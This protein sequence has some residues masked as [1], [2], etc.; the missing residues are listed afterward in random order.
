[1]AMLRPPKVQQVRPRALGAAEFDRAVAAHEAFV[2]GRSGGARA[3]LR[4]VVAQG[5]RCDRRTL[6]D[7]DFGG[8]DFTGSSFMASDLSRAVFYC[9]NLQ[10]C[11]LRAANLFEADLRGARL[12]GAKLVGAILDRANLRSAVLSSADPFAGGTATLT[13]ARLDGVDLSAVVA[14]GAD[15][16]NCSLKGAI[17]RHADL[18]Y[19]NLSNANLSGAQLEGVQLAG[20]QLRGAVL[21][22]VDLSKLS[23]PPEVLQGCVTDPSPAAAARVPQILAAL[24]AMDAWVRSGGREG[25]PAIFDN[26]DLRPVGDAFA[27]RQLPGVSLRNVMAIDASFRKAQLAGARFDGADLRG[28]DFTGADLR[29]VSFR[30]ANLAHA[31]FDEAEL[32]P[33]ALVNGMHREVQLEG[34]MLGGSSLAAIPPARSQAPAAVA[35]GA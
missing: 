26:E 29:G 35:S 31:C 16:S 10:L 14:R 8:S 5:V 11:D 32:G 28:A 20:A 13:D 6:C 34:A 17:L 27:N 19:A 12:A 30:G 15:L 33:L 9:T 25:S 1:M 18:N 24:D 4:L 21:C 22:G 2:A 7:A 3:Q 23:L